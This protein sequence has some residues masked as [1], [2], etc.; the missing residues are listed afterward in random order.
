[1]TV[2][3]E[4]LLDPDPQKLAKKASCR[5]WSQRDLAIVDN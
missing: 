2:V 3:A 5:I 4:D 1:M